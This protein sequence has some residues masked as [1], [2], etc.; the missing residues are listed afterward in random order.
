MLA[1]AKLRNLLLN[2]M[3]IYATAFYRN[4]RLYWA[5]HEFIE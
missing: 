5:K 1:I 2:Y 3:T 4:A